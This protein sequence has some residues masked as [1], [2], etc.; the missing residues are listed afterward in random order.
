M[1]RKRKAKTPMEPVVVEGIDISKPVRCLAFDPGT[2]NFACSVV[3]GKLVKG[4]FKFRIVGTCM[5]EYC[6]FEPK[7]Y[8]RTQARAFKK[9]FKKVQR[10]YGPFDLCVAER[11]QARGYGGH[12]IES[13]NMMLGIMSLEFEGKDF[14]TITAAIWKNAFNRQMD[15][16]ALYQERKQYEEPKTD[17]EFDASMIGT[18]RL[19]TLMGVLPFNQFEEEDGVKLLEKFLR[20]PKLK[21]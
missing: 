13:I 6:I 7:A 21:L 11:F 14:R 20:A 18:H 9:E 17:H 4:K 5:F 16:K 2:K 19:Q 3:E 1:A 15:L 8:L 10:K 12:T